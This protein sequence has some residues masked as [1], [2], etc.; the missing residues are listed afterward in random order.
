[1]LDRSDTT[2]SQSTGVKQTQ[3]C[4]T[5]CLIAHRLGIYGKRNKYNLDC[6]TLM[7]KAMWDE[8]KLTIIQTTQPRVAEAKVGKRADV[9]PDDDSASVVRERCRLGADSRTGDS[10]HKLPRCPGMLSGTRRRALLAVQRAPSAWRQSENGS[11]TRARLGVEY[12][13]LL[14]TTS[15]HVLRDNELPLEVASALGPDVQFVLKYID[16]DTIKLPAE[17]CQSN[18]QFRAVNI[19]LVRPGDCRLSP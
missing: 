16:D 15:I 9:L 18:Y 17:E 5:P 4:V 12:R 10:A 7:N 6:R 1:M 19:S 2:A 14:E 13:K 3:R 11:E 8:H